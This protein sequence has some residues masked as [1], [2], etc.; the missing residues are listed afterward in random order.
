MWVFVF[1]FNGTILGK[2]RKESILFI[3]SIG[4][5]KNN[6][7]EVYQNLSFTN[8][9]VFQVIVFCLSL[10]LAHLDQDPWNFSSCDIQYY[11]HRLDLYQNLF[12]LLF[13]I[14]LLWGGTKLYVLDQSCYQFYKSWKW[15]GSNV[16][17]VS[18]ALLDHPL[19]NIVENGC[20]Q[21]MHPND[22][23]RLWA[24]SNHNFNVFVHKSNPNLWRL[25][26]G[27]AKNPVAICF[28][29]LGIPSR[30]WTSECD[31]NVKS[32]KVVEK[33]DLLAEPKIWNMELDEQCEAVRCVIC[34]NVW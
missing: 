3:H 4:C 31:K 23:V 15:K 20:T 29:G 33:S 1:L 19:L 6:V 26:H 16:M 7:M 21:D 30:D 12:P 24:H 27:V 14:T 34:N 11:I 8:L 10:S 9:S 28:E 32:A 13:S 18:Y 2:L 5:S 17:K 25:A 22:A